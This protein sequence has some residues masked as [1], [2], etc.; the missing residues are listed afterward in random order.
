VHRL[1]GAAPA[2]TEAVGPDQAE[3]PLLPIAC[4]LGPDDGMR[5][6]NDWRRVASVGLAGQQSVP[7]RL[8][9]RFRDEPTVASELERLVAAE[10]DCCAFLGWNLVKVDDGWHVEITGDDA[11]LQAL[12]FGE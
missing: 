2:H 1:R 5:R 11:A 8:T 6:L 3:R 9:L 4:T 10:R 12:T 7:G